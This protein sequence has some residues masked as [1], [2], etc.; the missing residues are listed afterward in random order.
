MMI[1]GF[2]KCISHVLLA[3]KCSATAFS[4]TSS[5]CPS[6]AKAHTTRGAATRHSSAV[7]S[8]SSAVNFATALRDSDLASLEQGNHLFC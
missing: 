6:R 2:K 8:D 4:S 3:P 1:N 7:S 5:R